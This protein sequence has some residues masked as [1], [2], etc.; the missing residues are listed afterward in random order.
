[1]RVPTTRDEA[2]SRREALRQAHLDGQRAVDAGRLVPTDGRRAVHRTEAG[3]RLVCA[4]ARHPRRAWRTQ[5]VN[6]RRGRRVPFVTA[7]SASPARGSPHRRGG[8]APTPRR[9][10]R[11][12]ACASRPSSRPA[13]PRPCCCATF[14]VL[15]TPP[16]HGGDATVNA[17]VRR[18]V[19]R[20]GRRR[21][22]PRGR[23]ASPVIA[24][25]CRS[26]GRRRPIAS[27]RSATGRSRASAPCGRPQPGQQEDPGQTRPR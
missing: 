7:C 3:E 24:A 1:M 8:R 17:M 11:P 23:R 12:R 4:A 10:A 25:T 9:T 14:A 26:R 6:A 22:P 5:A 13:W 15:A 18:H 19:Q 16:V 2:A 20:R 21:S 27:A